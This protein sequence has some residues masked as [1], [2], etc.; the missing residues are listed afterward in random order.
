MSS[1][2]FWQKQRG[3]RGHTDDH[4]HCILALEFELE[5]ETLCGKSQLVLSL[6]DSQSRRIPWRLGAAFHVVSRD[7]PFHHWEILRPMAISVFI[8]AEKT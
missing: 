1:D 8:S 7:S 6:R 2:T 4:R 5:A 3:H